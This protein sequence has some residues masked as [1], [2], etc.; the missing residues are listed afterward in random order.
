[1]PNTR[2]VAFLMWFETVLQDIL[3]ALERGET[4]VE[5]I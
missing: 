4:L 1:L 5:V 2:R 3:S